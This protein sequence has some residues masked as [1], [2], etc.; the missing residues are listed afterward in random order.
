MQSEDFD[1]AV[2]RD[3]RLAVAEVVG[4]IQRAVIGLNLCPFA[5]GAQMSGGL[6][7][8]AYR[9]SELSD[10]AEWVVTQAQVLSRASHTETRVL[11]ILGALDDFLDFLDCIAVIEGTLEAVGLHETVQLA[12]FHPQYRFEGTVADDASNYTNRSPVPIIQLL[13]VS[14]VSEAVARHPDTL[15]IPEENIRRLRGLSEEDLRRL[16]YGAGR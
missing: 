3:E 9:A 4:W 16:Q 7:V 15:S 1:H 5:N 12:H 6:K 2:Q 13:L 14:A 8:E 11:A 10:A